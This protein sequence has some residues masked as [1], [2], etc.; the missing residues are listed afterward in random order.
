LL[1]GAAGRR[2][3]VHRQP[4]STE[5][6]A[7]KWRAIKRV[8]WRNLAR[9]IHPCSSSAIAQRGRSGPITIYLRFWFPVAAADQAPSQADFSSDGQT[10][11]ARVQAGSCL[12]RTFNW[13]LT[14]M[15]RDRLARMMA[16]TP[17]PR[18]ACQKT[19]ETRDDNSASSQFEQQTF[20]EF[21]QRA[22]YSLL[23]VT[24]CGFLRRVK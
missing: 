5:S 20:A 9:A 18:P 6:S 22:D 19:R 12:E 10:G 17:G 14:T 16:S 4:Q 24:A 21:A 7:W 8:V 1:A 11:L 13:T 23:E 2:A 3:F 15:W